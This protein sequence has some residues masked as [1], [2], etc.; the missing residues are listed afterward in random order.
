MTRMMIADEERRAGVQEGGRRRRTGRA[1][2]DLTEHRME[3]AQVA[4][5]PL[6]RLIVPMVL[7]DS[8]RRHARRMRM[9]DCVR[10]RAELGKTQQH[11]TQQRQEQAFHGGA[12][13]P[14]WKSAQYKRVRRTPNSRAPAG[15]IMVPS[16]P[17]PP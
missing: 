8:G 16:A 12:R 9:P 10:Q 15:S 1:T 2:E 17:R 14:E 6:R 13:N 3:G 4:L 11:G 7:R 5:C